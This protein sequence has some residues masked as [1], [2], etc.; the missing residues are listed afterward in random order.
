MKYYEVVGNDGKIQV[1]GVIGNGE[2]RNAD[3]S[4]A[5]Y[6]GNTEEELQQYYALSPNKKRGRPRKDK[7]DTK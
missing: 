1:V 7:E 5:K 3:N 4:P 2:A 6:I